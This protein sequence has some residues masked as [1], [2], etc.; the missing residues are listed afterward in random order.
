MIVKLFPAGRSF[1]GLGQYLG[2]DPKAT[3]KERVGWVQTL[4]CAN[5][6]EASAIDEMLWTFRNAE[7]L[8]QESGVIGG[9]VTAKPVKHWSLNWAP[10]QTPSRE[11]MQAATE[12][13]LR[14]MGWHEH[15]A[16]LYNHTDKPHSH[17]HI[18]LNAIHP[19]TGRHLDDGFEKRRAQ[20]WAA[21]FERLDGHIYCDQRLEAKHLREDNPSRD[22]WL[23]FKKA[24]QEFEKSE[25][26]RRA[27][28]PDYFEK[29]EN[30]KIIHS[31]EWKILKEF[32]K[33]ERIEFFAQGKE[34]FN[35]LRKEAFREIREEFRERWADYYV[36]KENGGDAD[37]LKTIHK[38]LVEEQK[39]ALANLRDER[40][41]TLRVERDE[42]YKELLSEHREARAELRE[43]QS[44]GQTSPY[45]L[46]LVHRDRSDSPDIV[47]EAGPRNVA[48]AEVQ[49][50]DSRNADVRPEE[51]RSDAAVQPVDPEQDSAPPATVG[52]V[53][54]GIDVVGNLG[55]GLIGGFGSLGDRL[56]DGFFGS[57]PTPK[58]AENPRPQVSEPQSETP[59]RNPF[60]AAADEARAR[61]ERQQE[62]S[63]KEW[64]DERRARS[65]E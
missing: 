35:E 48:S 16:I 11:E 65:R 3:T 6:D 19:D 21:E 37:E 43:R 36:A 14:D 61:A 27:F 28:N 20:K 58:Q 26:E 60:A 24:E 8:K 29:D 2:N 18:M 23:A 38:T 31:E 59:R 63:D 1:T 25:A 47:Q 54:P 30:R 22:K 15:E 40:C 33:N 57:A 13:F 55:F 34:E 41:A 17:V 12:W 9:G 39:L 44:E 45:L 10:D 32:Q 52:G 50:T 42:Q 51:E 49:A 7:L 62:E 5:S 56:F 46:D 64:W 53:R 4:N